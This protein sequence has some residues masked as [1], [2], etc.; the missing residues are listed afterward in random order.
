MN[1]IQ[2]EHQRKV[3]VVTGASGG[4]GKAT[5]A[6]LASKYGMKVFMLVRSE[7]RGRA[8]IDEITAQTPNA[9]LG[10][11][12]CDLGSLQSVRSAAETLIDRCHQIDVLVNNAGVVTVKREE[13]EDGFERMMGVNHL[14][15]FVLTGM[16]LPLLAKSP[17]GRIVVVSSGAHKIGR[18]NYGDPHLQHRF[19][20]WGG[21]GRSKLANNWFVSH[22][23]KQ[24][25]GSSITVNALHPGAVSTDIGVN[26]QT[27]FG[28][29]VHKLLRPFFLTA[30]QGADTAIYLATSEEVEDISGQYYYRRKLARISSLAADATE[31]E[32]FWRWSEEV[33]G[34]RWTY[35]HS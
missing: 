34:Y 14:G 8:A 5:A 11:V 4:M 17:A 30:E 21:Y 31:A 22:L 27:G 16:L 28:R 29:T 7:E 3:A 25:Q 2:D 26:R 24:L 9:D 33:T 15:H 32:R 12:I 10:L 20:V 18:M 19:T 23:D 13:T 1:V 6:A 35:P